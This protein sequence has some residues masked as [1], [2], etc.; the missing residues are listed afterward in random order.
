MR[1][2]FSV[3]IGGGGGLPAVGEE[4]GQTVHGMGGD[5]REHVPQVYKGIDLVTFAGGH[6][7]EEHGGGE[8]TVVGP[9]E[10]PVVPV[11]ASSP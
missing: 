4:F 11:M 9:E 8:A 6:E 3:G 1:V 10:G 2:E 5:S 7:A